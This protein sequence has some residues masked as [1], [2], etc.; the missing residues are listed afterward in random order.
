MVILIISQKWIKYF[1]VQNIAG[2]V[3]FILF[4][5]TPLQIIQNRKMF[6]IKKIIPVTSLCKIRYKIKS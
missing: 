1:D 5:Q 4:K 2:K 6:Q 3:L